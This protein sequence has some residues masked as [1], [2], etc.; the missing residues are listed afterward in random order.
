MY[1]DDTLPTPLRFHCLPYLLNK[2]VYS[3]ILNPLCPVRVVQIL[4]SMGPAL[5]CCQPTR[6][7]N[8]KEN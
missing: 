6:G 5:V 4:W 1:F 8:L 2:S 7:H 3:F